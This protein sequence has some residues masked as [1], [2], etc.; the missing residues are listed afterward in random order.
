M[1]NRFTSPPPQLFFILVCSIGFIGCDTGSGSSEDFLPMPIVARDDPAIVPVARTDLW[2]VER[3]TNILNNII[4]NQK[5]ILI[6]D[7]ITQGWEG[8]EEWGWERTEAWDIL[9]AKYNNKITNL[10]FGADH[11]QHVI[12]RLLNGE[13]PV[14]INPE[15]VVLMIGTQNSSE[16]Y[17]PKSVA[18]GIGEIIKIINSISPSTR[19]ILLSIFPRGTDNSNASRIFNNSVNNIIKTYNGHLN[20]MYYNIGQYYMDQNGILINELY[21]A[22]LLHLSSLGYILWKNK[23]IE[24]I[25]D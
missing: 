6:G 12:W 11:T 25:G 4:N 13:F 8:A 17:Q 5:I 18:A 7:S 2:W 23:I 10:G 15:Y 24:L 20:V 21:N 22:D 9:N 3:H 1:N 14:G 19:I 16:L